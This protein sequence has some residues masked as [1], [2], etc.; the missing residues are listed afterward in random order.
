MNLYFIKVIKK[1]AELSCI[2]YEKEGLSSIITRPEY[3][4]KK[5]GERP[6]MARW[7]K[8]INLVPK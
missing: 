3:L 8:E 4:P 7:N 2:I 5:I 6:E 1:Y